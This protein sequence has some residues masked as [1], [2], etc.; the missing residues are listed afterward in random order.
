VISFDHTPTLEAS[1]RALIPNLGRFEL[2][3]GAV[4]IRPRCHPDA[5]LTMALSGVWVA[6]ILTNLADSSDA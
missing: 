5:A 1:L 6:R 2:V 4:G 3:P